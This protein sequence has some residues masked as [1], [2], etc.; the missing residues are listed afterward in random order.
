M[1]RKHLLFTLKYLIAA[2]LLYYVLRQMDLAT[3]AG[4]MKRISIWAALGA[5]IA[6]NIGQIICAERMRY[7]YANAGQPISRK[8]SIVSY[9][10]G[11]FYNLVF[12]GGV[13]G[14]AYRVYLF[15]KVANLPVGQGIRIQLANR[16][17]GLL[18]M[19]LMILVAA[20]FIDVGI[21]KPLYWGGLALTAILG[22]GCYFLLMKWFI[23]EEAT[24]AWG[25]MLYSIAAQMCGLVTFALIW[26][27][28]SHGEGFAAYIVLFLTALIVSMLPVTI[29]GLGIREFVFLHGAEWLNGYAHLGI[30]PEMG[31]AFSLSFF[32]V[33]AA[34]ALIGL[35]L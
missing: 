30:S 7:Y 18:V 23:K 3:F 10:V 33:T 22:T 5:F 8:F 20:A 34:T 11:I 28:L 12:P 13:G 27:S 16:L 35:V 4:Y 25:A 17:N 32:A 14:D 29:G 1:K 24:S 31:V 19:S 26:A 6:F 15:K 21:S 9:Y 2:A